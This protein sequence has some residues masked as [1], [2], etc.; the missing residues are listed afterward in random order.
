[1]CPTEQRKYAMGATS[2][3]ESDRC[4]QRIGV[5]E[6]HKKHPEFDWVSADQI[7]LTMPAIRP[8]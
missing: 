7:V 4:Q 3:L 5:S 6:Q 2:F 1:M 8:V